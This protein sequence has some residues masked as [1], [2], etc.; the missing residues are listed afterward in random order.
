MVRRFYRLKLNHSYGSE[1]PLRL[2]VRVSNIKLFYFIDAVWM[3]KEALPLV[4]LSPYS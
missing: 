3:K 2:E 4:S 1:I